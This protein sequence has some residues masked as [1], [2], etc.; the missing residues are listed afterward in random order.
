[1]RK[2]LT[3]DSDFNILMI[4]DRLELHFEKKI[5]LATVSYID[6]E[7]IEIDA[8]G[9]GDGVILNV[10]KILAGQSKCKEVVKIDE[11]EYQDIKMCISRESYRA[12]MSEKRIN[13][14]HLEAIKATVEDLKMALY[15]ISLMD[16]IKDANDLA[17]GMLRDFYDYEGYIKRAALQQRKEKLDLK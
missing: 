3:N 6:E 15:K 11:D 1:L 14:A 7:G 17:D 16:Y 12:Y 10:K 2:I 4:G 9:F 8:D 13:E 5:T